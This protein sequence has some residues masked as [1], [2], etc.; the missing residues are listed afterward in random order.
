M[1]D[2][3]SHIVYDIDDGSENLEM[4]LAMLENSK[5]NGVETICATSHYICRHFEQDREKYFS[6]LEKLKNLSD[7]E[8]VPGLEVRI[9]YRIIKEYEEGRIW[10]IND[11]PYML[12]ELP[13]THIPKDAMDILHEMRIRGVKPILAHPER[14]HAVINNPNLVQ[15]FI[16][17]RVLIQVNG[18]SLLGKNGR[19][20]QKVAKYLVKKN[21]VHMLGSDGH[22]NTFR[23]TDIR[24]AYELVDKINPE[25]YKWIEE[26]QYNVINGEK[27]VFPH[28][29]RLKRQ[30]WIGFSR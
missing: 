24:A 10:G 13:F 26:N 15:D 1:I 28:I 30:F 16:K 3:H 11:G 8:I 18:D 20:V 4:S 7:I 14:Q 25:L 21:M 5:R 23:N 22:N 9:D 19:K 12:L 29:G 17:E 6:R 2:F 27:V